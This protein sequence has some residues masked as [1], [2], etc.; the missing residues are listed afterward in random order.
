MPDTCY[1]QNQTRIK[2]V[3]ST[4]TRAHMYKSKQCVLRTHIMLVTALAGSDGPVDGWYVRDHDMVGESLGGTRLILAHRAMP[5]RSPSFIRS[6]S[7]HWLAHSLT[8]WLAHALRLTPLT[9]V[10][11]L[12]ASEHISCSG[13]R[14][15]LSLSLSPAAVTCQVASKCAHVHVRSTVPIP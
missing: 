13:A 11:S 10:T 12:P 2:L 4:S 14:L 5:T 6:R 8:H 7:T 3:A 9:S 15:S 1:Q